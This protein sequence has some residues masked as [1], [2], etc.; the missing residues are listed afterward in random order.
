MGA[1]QKVRCLVCDKD[2]VNIA[3][4]TKSKSHDT[5]LSSLEK[6]IMKLYLDGKPTDSLYARIKASTKYKL[7]ELKKKART[8][9]YCSVCQ[10]TLSQKPDIHEKGKPHKANIVALERDIIYYLPRDTKYSAEL[11]SRIKGQTTKTLQRM[12]SESI[13]QYDKTQT[14]NVKYYYW[15]IFGDDDNVN[16]GDKAIKLYKKFLE[17]F[18]KPR[19]AILSVKEKELYDWLKQKVIERRG[20]SF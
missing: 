6:R 5:K 16:F 8:D 4:H 15:K 1:R 14:D 2:Y 13:E 10:K 11:Y 20:Q 19:K 3:G 18:K 9:Y 17:Y 7:K 12:K